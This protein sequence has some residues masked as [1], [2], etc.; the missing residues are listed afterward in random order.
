MF[1]QA[2]INFISLYFVFTFFIFLL[3]YQR[4]FHLF[5]DYYSKRH[6]R[7]STF[8]DLSPLS[9]HLVDSFNTVYLH[10]FYIRRYTCNADINVFVYP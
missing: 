6:I 9:N 5:N 3:I 7:N 10:G 8:M 4:Y 2:S 1:V